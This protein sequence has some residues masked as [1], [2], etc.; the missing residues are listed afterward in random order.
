MCSIQKFHIFPNAVPAQADGQH[1]WGVSKGVWTHRWVMLRMPSIY[2]VLQS[3][4][5]SGVDTKRMPDPVSLTGSSKGR[6]WKQPCLPVA[7]KA[8]G[9]WEF[10]QV[11]QELQSLSLYNASE[12]GASRV[13]KRS[14]ASTDP[15]SP[16]RPFSQTERAGSLV[17]VIAQA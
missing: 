16:R 12:A 8:G 10:Q 3:W 15:G 17:A 14:P 7:T 9:L 5:L 2:A 13:S 6:I 4:P 11:T 1:R